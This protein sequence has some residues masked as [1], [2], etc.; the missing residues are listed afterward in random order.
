MPK[1]FIKRHMPS[2]EKIRNIRSLQFLG[3]FLHEPNLW[4]INR[5]SVARA[6]LVGIFWCFI[7]MPFQMV[8]AALFAVWLNG[9]LPLS[10]ALV[11]IT[12]PLTMPPIFY[13]NYVIGAAILH[14]PAI[15]FEFRLSWQ[16][17]SERLVEVGIPL[18][19]GSVVCGLVF[20]CVSYVAIQ[21]LWRRRCAMN[22]AT[23]SAAALTTEPLNGRRRS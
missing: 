7:P 2:P 16:W 18:Y 17:L 5:H 13:F 21:F 15:P 22:G 19:F 3:R 12:N 23:V 9:N 14:R 11:W 8:A 4:H 20:G 10:V 6:F 1:N